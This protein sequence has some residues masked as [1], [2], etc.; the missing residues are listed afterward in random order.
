MK[1]V[2]VSASQLVK[3][4]SRQLLYKREHST[5]RSVSEKKKEGLEY[6]KS[7]LVGLPEMGG[8]Y[9][10]KGVDIYFSHDDTTKTAIYERKNVLRDDVEEWYFQQCILQC[11]LY[12]AL[13]VL[14]DGK[15][16]TSPFY[17][18]QT[19]RD[20]S[21]TVRPGFRYY[22]DMGGELWEIDARASKV[23]GYYVEKARS[24]IS[25]SFAE[26]WDDSHKHQE[27]DEL[28]QYVKYAKAKQ[29]A[30]ETRRIRL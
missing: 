13:T 15:L 21:I 28:R 7:R 3:C 14:T 16:R 24:S 17:R 4:S 19:G 29:K 9:A 23:A 20:D 30:R 12:L 18:K 22:L 2:F 8:H 5:K 25:W 26:H 11:A 1:P 10:S 6:Q 27:W